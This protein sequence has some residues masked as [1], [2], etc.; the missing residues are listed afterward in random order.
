MPNLSISIVIVSL[1]TVRLNN[2]SWFCKISG[3][4][5]SLFAKA[6]HRIRMSIYSHSQ[7]PGT[8][9]TDEDAIRQN[10]TVGLKPR[11]L[12]SLK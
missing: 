12:L 6:N 3:F 4:L 5:S 1:G 9:T 10:V 2:L 11:T 8:L 7:V